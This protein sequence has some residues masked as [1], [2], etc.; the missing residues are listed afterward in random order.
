MNRPNEETEGYRGKREARADAVVA[1][2]IGADPYLKPFERQL[3]HRIQLADKTERRITDGKTDLVEFASGHE[4]FGM[5][6]LSDGWVFREWAPKAT[7]IYL[8]GPF[9]DWKA[10]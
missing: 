3:L 4:Y 5:H 9:S 10:I 2:R 6:R 1:S 7:A 8:K